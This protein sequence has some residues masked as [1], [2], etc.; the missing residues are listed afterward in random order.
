MLVR[1]VLMLYKHAYANGKQK[2]SR[3]QFL[4]I[5]CIKNEKKSIQRTYI[6]ICC[7][8]AFIRPVIFRGGLLSAQSFS[9]EGLIGPPSHFHWR[10][11]VPLLDERAYVWVGG[12]G[13]LYNT[14]NNLTNY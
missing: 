2:H 5:D 7:G 12:G 11:F 6:C 8:R 4:Y 1:N 13:L 9:R 3:L 10:A 14:K